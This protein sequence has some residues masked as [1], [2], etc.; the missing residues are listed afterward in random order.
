MNPLKLISTSDDETFELMHEAN[1]LRQK[2]KGNKIKLCAIVN[3]KSGKCS[4]DCS[5]CAQSGHHHTNTAAYPLLS[6]EEI[7]QA[8]KGAEKNMGATCFSVVTSGKATNTKA[9]LETICQETKLN[10]C[11]SIGILTKPELLELKAK[12]LKRLHHNLETA[13]SFFDQVC[14]THIYEERLNTIKAAKEIGLE[15]CSGGIFGLGESLEQ[16]IELGL[17]LKEF[18]V[19]SVPI[20]ILNPIPGTPAAKNYQP[21]KPLEVLRLIAT[22]RLLMP[23]ADLGVFGG[24][25]KALG[26]LQP[27]MFLAG[28]NVTL[29]GDYLT[30]KGQQASQDLEMIKAL[31]LEIDYA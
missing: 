23:K 19:E 3:A 2:Y 6:S 5:F 31:G 29:V 9:E 22:Y 1:K 7:L 30:T 24:R 10:R 11:V 4:E 28:A 20:N 15:V 16:R 8:A 25:E 14:T 13:K 27:L 17:T 26:P 21:M 12:G 18:K